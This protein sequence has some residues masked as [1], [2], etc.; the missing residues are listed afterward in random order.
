MVCAV[1][2][3]DGTYKSVPKSAVQKDANDDDE[4]VMIDVIVLLLWILLLLWIIFCCCLLLATLTKLSSA[5]N[6]MMD[7]DLDL[8]LRMIEL[9]IL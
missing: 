6:A 9:R 5:I 2:F 7:W 3:V 1:S 8:W 4:E